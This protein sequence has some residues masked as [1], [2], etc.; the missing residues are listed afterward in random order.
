MSFY[1]LV[2][3]KVIDFHIVTPG[4]EYQID[5]NQKQQEIEK[6]TEIFNDET[7][8]SGDR[9]DA[10]KTLVELGGVS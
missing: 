2:E 1:G 10:L 9:W 3:A 8:E 7:G 6:A 5:Q 4:E